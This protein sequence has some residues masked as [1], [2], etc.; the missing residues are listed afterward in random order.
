MPA[1]YSLQARYLADHF[2]PLAGPLD[3]AKLAAVW[4]LAAAGMWAFRG[5]NS[6]KDAFKRNPAAP[7]FA[8]LRTIATPTGSR[9]LA[10][11]WWGVAR[12][13]NYLADWLMCVA[14]SLPTGAATPLTYF[15]PLYFAV[16]LVH[17][18]AR[19]EEKCA[20][21][22]GKAWVEYCKAVPWRIVPGVY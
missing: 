11:G 12:H 19:D 21:K 14:W 3:W 8:R 18:D 10:G 5:A 20:K 7:E 15:Y 2:S 22:Y 4:A 1:V 17:R 6:Q 9:L 16:L 13:V